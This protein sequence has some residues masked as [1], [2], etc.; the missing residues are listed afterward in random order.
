[1]RQQSSA[2]ANALITFPNLR[3][4]DLGT[5]IVATFTD[6]YTKI[7]QAWQPILKILRRNNGE[8]NIMWFYWM[9]PGMY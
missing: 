5:G 9:K 3:R 1:M 2:I 4:L 7:G 8:L 6:P